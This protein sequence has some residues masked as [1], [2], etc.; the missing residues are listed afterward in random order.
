VEYG[1]RQAVL[2]KLQAAT[3]QPSVVASA[4]T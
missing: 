3:P 2:A 1:P 4:H